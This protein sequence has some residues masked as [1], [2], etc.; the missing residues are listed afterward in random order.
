[1]KTTFSFRRV[2]AQSKYLILITTLL[3]F[4]Q[5]C[6][7]YQS[8]TLS[9]STNSSQND[10]N[11]P[12]IP[13]LGLN[14]GVLQSNLLGPMYSSLVLRQINCPDVNGK[15]MGFFVFTKSLATYYHPIGELFQVDYSTGESWK[16]TFD[17][18]NIGDAICHNNN[19]KVYI[20]GGYEHA[21]F[22]EID[23]V[24]HTN[25]LIGYLGDGAQSV[26]HDQVPGSNRVIISTS[27]VEGKVFTY[28]PDNPNAAEAWK[29]HGPADPDLTGVRYVF[30]SASE[31][32]NGQRY[33]YS[34]IRK[35]G[36]NYNYYFYYTAKNTV[37]G[38]VHPIWRG[39]YP[40]VNSENSVGSQAASVTV[41]ECT[42]Q[43]DQSL[44]VMISYKPGTPLSNAKVAAGDPEGMSY[45]Y[46]A[47]G[48]SEP[49]Y[50]TKGMYSEWYMPTGC[51]KHWKDRRY[52]GN[53][54]YGPPYE[55]DNSNLI[56]SNINNA[57]ATLRWRKPNEPWFQATQSGF[58]L[59]ETGI[60]QITYHANNIYAW[61]GLNDVLTRHT[62]TGAITK[63][64][65]SGS[66]F[67][68]QTFNATSR[69]FYT[70][71]Y[72]F[73]FMEFDP[74]Q[75]I[76]ADV[77][78]K[79]L[80][81]PEAGRAHYYTSVASAGKYVFVSGR[82]VRIGDGHFVHRFN[83]QTREFSLGNFPNFDVYKI[84]S[85]MG[86]TKIVA[87]T[88]VGLS[89]QVRVID[90]ETNTIE[91]VI[92][93]GTM[94]QGGTPGRVAETS[95]GKIVL[96]TGRGNANGQPRVTRIDLVSGDVQSEI[97]TEITHAEPDQYSLDG[98]LLRGP[99]GKVWFGAVK[100]GK[101]G[102]Y[103][104][105]DVTN[106]GIFIELLKYPRS[107]TF[108]VNAARNGFDLV[109]VGDSTK[110]YILKDVLIGQ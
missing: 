77:N 66:S 52:T 54:F 23:P 74:T 35:D 39:S 70:A 81:V 108:A 51:V 58:N 26:L 10:P 99:D 55:I 76:T 86:G 60:T 20:G 83:T 71:G 67:Y 21:K 34:T 9:S 69:K 96:V 1:M 107:P 98:E 105:D 42:W 91:R 53:N 30:G 95:P 94:A 84:I 18:S 15:W 3:V 75:P 106:T 73:K 59:A 38:E 50:V 25:K 61:T 72:P 110:L 63:L 101:S 68:A 16:T 78:P 93:T 90:V 40:F 29:D 8:E 4:Y 32:R 88:N 62:V 82:K 97:L 65:P 37:T 31:I 45:W 87:T 7:S 33:I 79:N 2:V 6:S 109:Y 64:G 36:G 57:T 100:N 47:N 102:I 89:S 44:S 41:G 56:P 28:D 11:I 5:N 46:K 24:N 12:V 48:F 103:R 85:V 49:I 27:G 92:D 14:T 43:D 19:G 17:G 80:D 104:Y 22:W 13:N